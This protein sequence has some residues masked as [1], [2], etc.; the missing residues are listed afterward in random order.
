VSGQNVYVLQSLHG[1]PSLSANDK[2]CR[3]LF[4]IGSLK[5]AGAAR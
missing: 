1:G 4:F 5:D 3:L 2:L